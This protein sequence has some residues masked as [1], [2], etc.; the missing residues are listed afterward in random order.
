[1]GIGWTRWFKREDKVGVS[2]QVTYDVYEP[3]EAGAV[4]V[5]RAV[6]GTPTTQQLQA[7]AYYALEAFKDH[8]A[9]GKAMKDPLETSWNNLQTAAKDA[10]AEHKAAVLQFPQRSPGIN[11]MGGVDLE[12][13]GRF[14]P[15]RYEAKE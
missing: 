12:D 13:E 4:R 8:I 9:K 3:D 1:M 6:A 14:D 15:K 7:I 11:P 2:L 10:I 5:N